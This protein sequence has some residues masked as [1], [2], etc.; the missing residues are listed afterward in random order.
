[1]LRP[2]GRYSCGVFIYGLS[3]SSFLIYFWFNWRSTECSG[4]YV[5][6]FPASH[7]GDAS[8]NSDP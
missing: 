3:C 6:R 2:D 4:F 8:L 7:S 1:M 5:A